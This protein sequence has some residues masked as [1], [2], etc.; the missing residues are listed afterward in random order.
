LPAFS[1]MRAGRRKIP[2]PIIILIFMRTAE[3]KEIL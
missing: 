1:A 3:V 2:A